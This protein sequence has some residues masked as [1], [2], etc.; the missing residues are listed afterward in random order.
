MT[1]DH[2]AERRE[3]YRRNFPPQDMPDQDPTPPSKPHRQV[4]VVFDLT[5]SA[6]RKILVSLARQL[7]KADQ[8]DKAAAIQGY[9][10]GSTGLPAQLQ[11]VFHT[12]H[13]FEVD[14]PD[15]WGEYF[16]GQDPAA[17]WPPLVEGGD[18]DAA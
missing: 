3:W 12:G 17:G 14:K 5:N 18:P 4:M 10:D 13:L 8:G 16:D 9:L 15:S 2:D 7:S 6:H 1:T 11:Q